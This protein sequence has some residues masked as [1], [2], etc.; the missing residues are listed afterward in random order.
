MSESQLKRAPH[1][2]GD[3]R[4]DR[5]LKQLVQSGMVWVDDQADAE[6]LYWFPSLFGEE[7]FDEEVESKN[8]LTQ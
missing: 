5:A 3:Q 6:R 1:N 2:W 8:E 7:F 4:I